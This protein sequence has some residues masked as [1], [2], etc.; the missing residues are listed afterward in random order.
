MFPKYVLESSKV[1]STKRLLTANLQ[2][3]D[4]SQLRLQ[5]L[6]LFSVVVALPFVGSDGL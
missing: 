3:L 1:S 5:H 2:K 6:Y 4:V